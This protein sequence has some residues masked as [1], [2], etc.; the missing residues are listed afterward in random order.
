MISL[1]PIQNLYEAEQKQGSY[2][3]FAGL[4]ILIACLGLFGLATFNAMQ[5]VKEIGIERS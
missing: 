1:A 5:R 2:I 4:A 3:I